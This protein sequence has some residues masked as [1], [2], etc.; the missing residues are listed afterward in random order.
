M[1]P[2][3]PY[4]EGA[5]F[6]INF[7]DPGFEAPKNRYYSVIGSA[8]LTGYDKQPIECWLLSHGSLPSSYQ[9]FWISKKTFE[10]LKLEEEYGGKFRYKIKL[11]FSD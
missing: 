8:M 2:L 3:L 10:V 5:V 6:K 1:F 9:V 11:G 4:K 7:Y